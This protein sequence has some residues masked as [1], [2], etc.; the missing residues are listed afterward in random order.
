MEKYWVVKTDFLNKENQKIVNEFLLNMKVANKSFNTI[1]NIRYVMQA[2]FKELEVSYSSLVSNDIQEWLLKQN[3]RLKDNTIRN[4]VSALTQFY[5][6][7]VEE[8]YMD[9]SPI[10]SRWMPR[11]PK[12]VPRYLNRQE[13]A[14]VRQQA[15]HSF[16]RDRVILEFLV[17]SGCRVGEVYLLDKKDVDLE[18]R[19]AQVV[20]KGSKIRQVHFSEKCNLLLDRYFQSRKD[21]HPALFISSKKNPTRLS[22][23]RIGRILNQI[24]KRAK[25][26]G[27][28]HP[29]RLRHTFATELLVKGADLLFIADELGHSDIE[30]TKIYARFPKQEIISMYRKYMG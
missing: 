29:H 18:N 19:T 22:I 15:E 1:N 11:S 24:G 23:R 7:C 17:T 26:S 21:D 28:L 10:K 5:A 4:R 2:F 27:S 6:F 25:L 8:G 20:G 13:I 12:P 3:K 14:K 30:T 9:K 16:L